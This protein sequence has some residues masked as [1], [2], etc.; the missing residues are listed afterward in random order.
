[1][2]RSFSSEVALENDPVSE[3]ATEVAEALPVGLQPGDAVAVRIV[4]TPVTER[5][6]APSFASYRRHDQ[7]TIKI[8]LTAEFKGT[9]E[10]AVVD[11]PRTNDPE[12][13]IID[14]GQIPVG[15]SR[16][17]TIYAKNIGAGYF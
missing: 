13:Q 10:I 14:F 1:M 12:K 17:L 16:T 15:E 11:D 8:P 6:I 9:S 4:Y 3:F 7:P 2:T 5:Q